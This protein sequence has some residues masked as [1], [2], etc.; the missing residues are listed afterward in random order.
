MSSQGDLS[1]GDSLPPEEEAP[2]IN[3][4]SQLLHMKMTV[5]SESTLAFNVTSHPGSYALGKMFFME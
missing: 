2:A 5:N 1:R 3:R 4:F